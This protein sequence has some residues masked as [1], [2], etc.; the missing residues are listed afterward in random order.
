MFW[1]PSPDLYLI[2][3]LSRSSTDN[4]FNLMALFLL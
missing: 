4:S 1:D 2:T 3:I